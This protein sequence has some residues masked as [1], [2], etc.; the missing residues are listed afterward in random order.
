M[1]PE[2]SCQKITNVPVFIWHLDL[3]ILMQA[4]SLLGPLEG[5]G[6]EISGPIPSNGPRNEYCLHQNHY[7]SRHINN[8]Y[9]NS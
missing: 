2:I 4:N 1:G 7:V 6:P 9:I 5:V 3:L 8:R